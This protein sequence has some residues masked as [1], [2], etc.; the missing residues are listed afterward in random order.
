MVSNQRVTIVSDVLQDAHL[1]E[2]INAIYVSLIMSYLKTQMEILFAKKLAKLLAFIA[3]NKFAS[4]VPKATNQ[5]EINV[6]LTFLATLA[7]IFVYQEHLNKE[8]NA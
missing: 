8:A 2:I 5:L 7:V 4:N 6:K 3:N 1:A